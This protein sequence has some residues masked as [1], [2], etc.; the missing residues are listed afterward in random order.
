MNILDGQDFSLTPVSG[1]TD[2]FVDLTYSCTLQNCQL[3]TLYCYTA[4]FYCGGNVIFQI[5]E[6]HFGYQ[7]AF[8]FVPFS[9]ERRVSGYV[10]SFIQ[11]VRSYLS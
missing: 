3:F 4:V 11:Y 1:R 10:R 5:G 6:E 2:V 7:Q 8:S 9:W